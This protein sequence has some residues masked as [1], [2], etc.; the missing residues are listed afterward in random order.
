MPDLTNRSYEEELLDKPNIPR[1]QLFQNLKELD[2]VNQLLGGHAVTLKGVTQLMVDKSRTYSIV[3]FGC[4]SGDTLQK[5]YKWGLKKNMKLQLTGIDKNADTIDYA[6][7]ANKNFP[8]INFICADFRDPTIREIKF[9]IAINCLFCHHLNDE[10]LIKFIDLMN[11]SCSVGFVINDLHRHWFAYYSI[12]YITKIFSRS[13]L[14]KN[15]APLS[16]WKAFK[17]KELKTYLSKS[18]IGKYKIS[19]EWAFRFLVVAKTATP[20]TSHVG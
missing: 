16:V 6:K 11:N 18:G 5:L 1:K 12:K 19:W 4:G 7:Q 2:M 3:D 20:L 8:A 17:E 15:D 10:Q 9:D 13:V 14:V